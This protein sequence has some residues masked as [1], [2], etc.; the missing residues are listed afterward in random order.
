MGHIMQA[1][2]VVVVLAALVVASLG[3]GWVLHLTRTRVRTPAAADSERLRPEAFT[4]PGSHVARFGERLTLVQFS[5]E[6]CARCPATARTLSRA[7]DTHT[8][9]AHVEVDVTT[10]D[11][12]ISRFNILRTPT[13]LI[14]D[15]SGRLRTRVS[16]P[17]SAAQATQLV[18]LA[19]APERDPQT[20]AR[21]LERSYL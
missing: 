2:V 20:E 3:L 16:G 14:L 18:D 10:R 8:G 9:V 11:D 6:M 17:I 13:V 15:G 19:L 4:V 7:A 5:T 21:L 12:L 1:N